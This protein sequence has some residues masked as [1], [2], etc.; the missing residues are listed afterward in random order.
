MVVRVDLGGVGVLGVGGVD[1]LGLVVVD[2][3]FG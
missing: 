3:L 2:G 1:D